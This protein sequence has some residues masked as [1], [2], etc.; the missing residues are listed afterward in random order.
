ML[1]VRLLA[2]PSTRIAP[3]RLRYACA[4]LRNPRRSRLDRLAEPALKRTTPTGSPTGGGNAEAVPAIGAR[5]CGA[6]PCAPAA[7]VPVPRYAAISVGGAPKVGFPS[8]ATERLLGLGRVASDRTAAPE[9][10]VARA[11]GGR[12]ANS[13]VRELGVGPKRDTPDTG[14]T[15]NGRIDD[16]GV[17]AVCAGA[18]GATGL[19]AVKGAGRG[20]REAVLASA[21]GGGG[22]E[23]AASLWRLIVSCEYF[24]FSRSDFSRSARRLRS[25]I[26]GALGR[27]GT[28]ASFGKS[29]FSPDVYVGRLASPEDIDSD[30]LSPKIA[31]VAPSYHSTG[32][33]QF[34]RDEHPASSAATRTNAPAVAKFDFLVIQN[35]LAKSML[36]LSISLFFHTFSGCKTPKNKKPS[37]CA[38][39]QFVLHLLPLS[40]RTRAC[41][42]INYGSASSQII[43][44]DAERN[45][46]SPDGH[47]DRAYLLPRRRRTDGNNRE[48]CR[49]KPANCH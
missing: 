49:A 16:G 29:W 41:A 31:S 4:I 10:M 40:E 44:Y 5:G 17:E 3:P 26:F 25:P 2:W 14:G 35:F 21:G 37:Y 1:R 6:N 12:G 36:I 39:Q 45:K 19:T 46:G 34:G 22:V 43:P 24:A 9:G 33:A 32:L 42:A 30:S 7:G 11:V 20:C 28:D 13:G 15:S 23:T 18:R 38:L 48:N 27:S 47:K 8:R